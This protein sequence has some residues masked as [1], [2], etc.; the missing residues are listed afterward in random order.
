MLQTGLRLTAL[1]ARTRN[2]PASAARVAGDIASISLRQARTVLQ[3][4]GRSAPSQR[5]TGRRVAADAAVAAR[6]GASASAARAVRMFE[7]QI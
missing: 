6:I 4:T 7:F 1:L 2:L 3:L 5:R